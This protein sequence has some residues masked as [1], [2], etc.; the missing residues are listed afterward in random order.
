M[1]F[2]EDNDLAAE[3]AIDVHHRWRTANSQ[4][5]EALA[6]LLVENKKLIDQKFRKMTIDICIKVL[7]GESISENQR[8]ALVNAYTYNFEIDRDWY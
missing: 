6:E 2:I 8:K 5:N 7:K 3:Y 1:S 4:T